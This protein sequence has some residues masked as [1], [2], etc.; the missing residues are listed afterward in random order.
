VV[1]LVTVHWQVLWLAVNLAPA[2][3][4][5]ARSSCSIRLCHAMQLP[6]LRT[7]WVLDAA[8]LLTH[9]AADDDDAL[10]CQQQQQQQQQ[11]GQQHSHLLSLQLFMLMMNNTV[12]VWHIQP[13]AAA[14]ETE[15]LQCVLRAAC[16]S[17]ASLYSGALLLQQ[18]QSGVGAGFVFAEQQ[19]G[20]STVRKSKAQP[21]DA[22]DLQHQ[23]VQQL[24]GKCA[25]PAVWVAA[26]TA[27]GEILLWQLPDTWHTAAAA[28]V[29]DPADPAGHTCPVS[30]LYSSSSNSLTAC[31]VLFR[32]L[33][34]EG[35]IHRV[36]WGPAATGDTAI[37]TAHHTGN[38]SSSSVSSDDALQLLGSCSDDRTCRLWLLPLQ[39]SKPGSAAANIP[40]AAAAEQGES[41]RA[42]NAR[43]QCHE[44]VV[45]KPYVTLWGHTA[46]VWDVA[47]LP[48]HQQ[49]QHLRLKDTAAAAAA[50]AAGSHSSSS[51]S[52]LLVATASEDCSV[53]LW[54]GGATG[55]Q[56]AELQVSESGGCLL[57]AV[58]VLRESHLFQI[59]HH[60]LQVEQLF[61]A[62]VHVYA[63][64]SVSNRAWSAA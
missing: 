38:S 49:Q 16:S 41:R 26:G 23:Q 60:T 13:A 12:Q 17:R 36:V 27:F 57:V 35:S 3:A 1:L 25:A 10:T 63:R 33:G 4:A 14:E 58:I 37:D 55:Q 32:L 24:S 44:P 22:H 18:Q 8:L 59:S 43:A 64:L 15:Q 40:A 39:Q 53:R 42:S 61:V 19:N 46:R 6:L 5:T 62:G 29:T 11:L 30:N 20:F 56:L 52:R 45:G 9:A 7:Q 51:S 34:H 50:A 48:V 31:P 21:R 28:A 47:L 2:A 54:D